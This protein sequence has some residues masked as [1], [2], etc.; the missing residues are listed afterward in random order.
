[1]KI[2]YLC[3]VKKIAIIVTFLLLAKPIL[4]LI[5]YCVNYKYIANEL[6]ENQDKP[7]LECNGKCH[8]KKE[9]AKA[10]TEENSTSKDKKQVSKQEIEILFYQEAF[11]FESK[12]ISIVYTETP[13]YYFNNYFHLNSSQIFHP[14]TS[15]V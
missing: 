8:L 4:P 13:T 11:Q 9:L 1:M 10:A 7:E 12:N 5:D 2:Y 3:T 6:C 14:P 15:L